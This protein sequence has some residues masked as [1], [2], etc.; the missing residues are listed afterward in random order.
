MFVGPTTIEYN[1]IIDTEMPESAFQTLY[2]DVCTA[3]CY[4]SLQRWRENLV[5]SCQSDFEKLF[6]DVSI[7]ETYKGPD[8]ETFLSS[9]ALPAAQAGK[10]VSQ[11][12]GAYAYT[13]T[14]WIDWIFWQ[15]C[16]R[17]L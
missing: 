2:G 5:G 15:K 3:N 9:F 4:T 13:E 10:D 17:D 7:S 11:F 6:G 16:L 1:Y 12:A 8:T 14:Q